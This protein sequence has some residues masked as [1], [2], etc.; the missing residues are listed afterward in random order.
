MK[1]DKRKRR[2]RKGGNISRRYHNH[3]EFSN[4]VGGG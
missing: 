3:L 1:K 2:R 4:L